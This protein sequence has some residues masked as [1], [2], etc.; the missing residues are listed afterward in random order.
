MYSTRQ[1]PTEFQFIAYLIKP[2]HLPRSCFM[3]NNIGGCEVGENSIELQ[4]CLCRDELRHL[5]GLLW[6][7]ANSVHA[8][9]DLEVY[10][11]HDAK[12][13]CNTSIM[14]NRGFV[15]QRCNE[16]V[17]DHVFML[18][19]WLLAHHQD[20]CAHTGLS[21]RYCF[22][23]KRNTQATCTTL[24]CGCCTLQCTMSI[25]IGLYYCP[26]F[27]W[28]RFACQ[29]VHIVRQCTQVDFGPCPARI[30]AA[31]TT[32][33]ASCAVC[34]NETCHCEIPFSRASLSALPVTRNVG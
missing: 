18:L 31:A 6:L 16:P 2:V 7:S 23:C 21:K 3:I 5:D 14:L 19:R 11:T 8:R 29:Y 1:K 10:S 27:A 13:C 26:Y 15:V 28:C 20:R 12:S 32:A 33:T 9:V 4:P 34:D 25:S 24:K 22:I 30:H 17:L